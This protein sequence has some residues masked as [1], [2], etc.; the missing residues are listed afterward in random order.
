MHR[1]LLLGVLLLMA[2]ADLGTA[3]FIVPDFDRAAWQKD[4]DYFCTSPIRGYHQKFQGEGLLRITDLRCPYDLVHYCPEDGEQVHIPLRIRYLVEKPV[5]GAVAGSGTWSLWNLNGLS[6]SGLSDEQ[7]ALDAAGEQTHDFAITRFV[8]VNVPDDPFRTFRPLR[9]APGPLFLGRYVYGTIHH[10][11]NAFEPDVIHLQ[12]SWDKGW[13][14][15]DEQ[16]RLRFRP[17]LMTTL[18]D[19]SQFRVELSEPKGDPEGTRRVTVRLTVPDAA[20]RVADVVRGEVRL[21]VTGR[22]GNAVEVALAPALD[23]GDVPLGYFAGELPAAPEADKLTFRA[24][25]SCFLPG[26]TERTVEATLE[27]AARE[28]GTLPPPLPDHLPL[29]QV[30]FRALFA[31]AGPFFRDGVAETLDRMVQAGLNTLLLEVNYTTAAGPWRSEVANWPEPSPEAL[32]FGTVAE[33]AKKRN[34][35]V[36]PCF[37]GFARP[38]HMPA[39]WSS[40]DA[41]GQRC[42]RPSERSPEFRR[43]LA[44]LCGECARRFDIAGVVLD[45]IRQPNPDRSSTAQVQYRVRFG[46]DLSAD[47]PALARPF[48][49]WQEESVTALV[50]AVRD[51]VRREKPEA[52]LGIC[53]YIGSAPSLRWN[54]AEGQPAHVWLNTGLIDFAMPMVYAND[55][56][57]VAAPVQDYLLAVDYPGRIYPLLAILDTRPVPT[58]SQLVRHPEQIRAQTLALY[59]RFGI[60]G[61]GYYPSSYL[62]PSTIAALQGLFQGG[63]RE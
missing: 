47:A 41:A 17:Q 3:E 39:E 24:R 1:A 30:P 34:I 50:R 23:L 36:Y 2:T 19:L 16:G 57:E 25:V 7:L 58:W 52:H 20:G 61:V 12:G 48:V 31:H 10:H 46:R 18:A 4:N 44:A 51:A 21:V 13:G 62:T 29:N 45:G 60:A 14:A 32:N 11:E 42:D 27:V 35:A 40:Y 5:P 55:Y 26:G 8:G 59:Q 15:R 63:E 54:T 6:V 9:L 33:E 28:L 37:W 38:A 49:E 56:Q 22:E 53:A 43:W